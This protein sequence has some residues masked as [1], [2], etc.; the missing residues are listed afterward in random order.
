[1]THPVHQLAEVGARVRCE[2]V[3]GMAQIMKVD[4]RAR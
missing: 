3:P 1:V 4:R 2:H